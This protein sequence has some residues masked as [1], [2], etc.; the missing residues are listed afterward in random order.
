MPLRVPIGDGTTEGNSDIPANINYKQ[1][2]AGC[3]LSSYLNRSVLLA[4]VS[5]VYE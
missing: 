4:I 3:S 2:L 5:Y 1:D